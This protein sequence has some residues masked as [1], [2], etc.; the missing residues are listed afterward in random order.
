LTI[1]RDCNLL[2]PF[3]RHS[4]RGAA[5]N[6]EEDILKINVN[7]IPEGGMPVRFERDGAWFRENLAGTASC[8]FLPDRIDVASTVRRI[9]ENV[10]IEG[11]VAATGEM[12]CCRCL[13]TA[14]LQLRSAFK[15]TFA[16]SPAQPEEDAELKAEDLDFAYYEGEIIDL[17]A[18]ILEQILLQIP[19]KPLCTEL[20]R[21]LCPR[22]GINLNTASCNCQTE[23][24]DERF[25]VLKKIKD[26]P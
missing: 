21:G 2:R 3:A 12:P 14:H 16:P 17:D 18:V 1:R 22:C 10:F 9:R 6:A 23:A 7:K 26:Q 4:C 11:T 24:V 8:D 15:Y 13:E 19:I 20:C 5:V 25:A